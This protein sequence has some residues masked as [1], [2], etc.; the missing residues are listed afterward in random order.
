MPMRRCQRF[1]MEQ[2]GLLIG[3]RCNFT[4]SNA[5]ILSQ[6]GLAQAAALTSNKGM[7]DAMKTA[8]ALA[9][10]SIAISISSCATTSPVVPIGNGRYEVT[11]HSATAF[12]TAGEQK[13]KLIAACERLLLKARQAG[14]H[15]RRARRQ[16]AS[17]VI[18]ASQ[19]RRHIRISRHPREVGYCR[20]GVFLPVGRRLG[21]NSS[22]T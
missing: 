16:R 6:H 9:V 12:G 5:V 22:A 11:G 20:C 10:A 3:F 8:S 18:C 7:G 19:R 17:R 4:H 1:A 13:V 2:H 15:R 21:E 14:Q